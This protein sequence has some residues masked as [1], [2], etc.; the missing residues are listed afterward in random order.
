M[1]RAAWPSRL[2][3]GVPTRETAM[4]HKRKLAAVIAVIA[5][6]AHVAWFG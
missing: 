1:S 2:L 4:S 6:T 3:L 5:V